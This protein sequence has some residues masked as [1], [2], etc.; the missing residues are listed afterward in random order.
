MKKLLFYVLA[1]SLAVVSCQKTGVNGVGSPEGEEGL[2]A[3]K[4]N[5]LVINGEEHSLTGVFVEEYSGYMM[6]TATDVPGAESFDWLI[7]N[8]A[9]YVQILVMPS[10]YGEEFDALTETDAFAIYSTYESA[11]LM[12]GVGPGYTEGLES[13]LCRFDFDGSQAE[14]FMDLTLADGSSLAVRASGQYDG[15]AAPD[16]NFIERNG[17]KSPLRASFYSVEDG[18]GYFYFTPA[19]IDYF[20]EIDMAEYYIA[21]SFDEAVLDAGTVDVNDNSLFFD[22]FYVDNFTGDMVEI[23]SD[24]PAGA[25]GTFSVERLDGENSFAASMSIVFSDDLSVSFGFSG[26]CT[27]MYAEPA[28]ENEFEYDGTTSPISSVVLDTTADLWTIWLSSESGIETVDAMQSADAVK[29]SA[30][31]EAFSGEPV[32]FSTYK[33]MEFEYD[34]NVWNYENGSLGTLTVSLDGENMLLEFTNYDNFKGYYS[35]PVVVIR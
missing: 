16:E 27:D 19:D 20:E 4:P 13:G 14:M 26:E 8:N 3:L 24:D 31:E 11:P 1:I 34:G 22:I 29:I 9:E 28:K 12:D 25:E 10:L 21:M 32:G 5:T 15:S 35:G 6:I 17:E 2:D 30:P 7:D 23:T 33:D 18:Y